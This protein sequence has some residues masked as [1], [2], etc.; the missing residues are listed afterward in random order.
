M[1]CLWTHHMNTVGLE[2][3]DINIYSC[4]GEVR[5]HDSLG[6]LP[7]RCSG[8]RYAQSNSCRQ[9]IR[10]KDLGKVANRMGVYFVFISGPLPRLHLCGMVQIMAVSSSRCPRS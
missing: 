8:Y 5:L 7:Q 6:K 9:S 2:I 1:A 3:D 10:M 4:E